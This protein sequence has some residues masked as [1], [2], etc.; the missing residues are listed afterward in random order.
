MN[1]RKSFAG[2]YKQH[3]PMWS[4]LL[5]LSPAPGQEFL[6]C[7]AGLGRIR[8]RAIPLPTGA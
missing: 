7:G 6:A 3:I 1:Q 8:C 2:F 4:R 5:L